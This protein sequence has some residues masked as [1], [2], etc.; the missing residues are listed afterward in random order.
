MPTLIVPEI[1][2]GSCKTFLQSLI[3]PIAGVKDLRIDIERRILSFSTSSDIS[4]EKLIDDVEDLLAQA[5]YSVVDEKVGESSSDRT[6]SPVE[7]HAR[8]LEHCAACRDDAILESVVVAREVVPLTLKTEF[9]IE[10]MTCASCTTSITNALQGLPGVITV[11]VKLMLNS[12]TVIHDGN[13]VSASDVAAEIESI[14]FDASV[15][16]SHPVQDDP[17]PTRETVFGVVGMTCSSCSSPL[18]KAVSAMKGV[19]L[20]SVSLVS[21]SMTVRYDPGQVTIEDI[22]ATVQDCGF[23]VSETTTR[24]LDSQLNSD[25]SERV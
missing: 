17:A 23:E 13:A 5:G 7:Q 12:A 1:H 21:N 3:S 19:E 20:A 24:D 16:T 11:D 2:C 22:T 14:G 6:P 8:H 25:P 9:A 10:G 4:S 18:S 15:T